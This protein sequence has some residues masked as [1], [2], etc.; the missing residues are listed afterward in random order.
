TPGEQ[1]DDPDTFAGNRTIFTM[2][3]TISLQLDSSNHGHFDTEEWSE[4]DAILAR[5]GNSLEF[6]NIYSS[7]DVHLDSAA[8]LTALKEKTSLD[9][10]VKMGEWDYEIVLW[11][12][13][14]VTQEPRGGS[15]V[16]KNHKS[17]RPKTDF[18]RQCS[19]KGA[20]TASFAL[21]HAAYF[22]VLVLGDLTA[23]T[24]SLLVNIR[25]PPRVSMDTGNPSQRGRWLLCS[26]FNDYDIV[27]MVG[28]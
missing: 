23:R 8:E 16:K 7:R 19:G 6:V 26:V 11:G 13:W 27:F 1:L 21:A 18:A 14:L 3:K 12:L 15:S 25:D 20:L 17:E 28:R 4:L 9:I 24:A 10:P 22:L 2:L 5:A